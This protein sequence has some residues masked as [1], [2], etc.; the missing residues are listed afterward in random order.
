MKRPVSNEDARK[1]AH[2]FNNLLTAI[3]GAAEAILERSGIDQETRDD[4]AHVREGARRG[5]ML[6]QRLRGTARNTADSIGLI[7]INDAIRATSR[8]L[9]HSLGSAITL[10]LDLQAEPEQVAIDPSQLDRAL[11]NLLANAR[12]AMPGGGTVTLGTLQRTVGITESRVPDTIPPGKYVV[13]SV[14]DR[15]AG[16]PPAQMLRIFDAGVSS[17]HRAGGSGFGLSSTRDIV[18][19]SNGFL[20]VESAEG[21]GTRFEIHLPLVASPCRLAE[22]SAARDFTVLLVEDDP[23]VRRV[24]ERALHRRGW[25]V[26]CAGSAEEAL[27]ILQGRHCD[28]LISDVALPAMDGVALARQVLAGQP[29]IPIILTSGYERRTIGD[30]AKVANALFLTKPYGQAELLDA[31]ARVMAG[32]SAAP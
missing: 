20:S 15:G 8:L 31:I 3:I 14:E 19:H 18:R 26:L 25:N 10:A 4:I 22:P 30:T 21:Q 17:R 11:L 6:V 28:L 23:F 1:L 2:D 29:N 5:T 27:A 12:H 24:S 16:I 13:I 7:S 9:D 32:K